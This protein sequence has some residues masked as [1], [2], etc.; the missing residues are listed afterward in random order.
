[1]NTYGSDENDLPFRFMNN[2]DFTLLD[3]TRTN[4][5]KLFS[6][7]KGKEISKCRKNITPFIYV[8]QTMLS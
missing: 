1:M 2:L 5:K 4:A 3:Q 8:F 7:G 6:F